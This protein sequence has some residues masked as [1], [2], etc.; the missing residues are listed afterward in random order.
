MHRTYRT[1]LVHF[2]FR[3]DIF[4]DPYTTTPDF[5]T[6]RQCYRDIFT[7]QVKEI[8]MLINKDH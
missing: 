2:V 6:S 3:V 8:T 5:L 7:R 4:E 1:V